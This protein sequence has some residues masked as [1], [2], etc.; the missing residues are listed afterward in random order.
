MEYKL[1]ATD[2]DGTLINSN[3][4]IP[5]SN[6]EYIKKAQEAGIVFVLASGRPTFAMLEIAKELE[7]DK[8]GGYILSYNGGEILNCK[9]GEVI[10]R[11]GLSREDVDNMYNYS[12]NNDISFLTY[13][14]NKLIT[15]E[16]NEYTRL[17]SLFTKGELNLI[18][19]LE[20]IKFEQVIKC[21]LI[22]N[23]ESVKKHSEILK[24]SEYAKNMFFAIS[25][26][27]FLEVVNINVNKGNALKRLANMLKIDISQTIAVGDSY[28]DIPLLSVTGL[29]VAPSNAKE[30]IKEMV[31]YVGVSNDEGI[32]KDLIEKYILK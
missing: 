23:E 13:N 16:D 4:K 18:D 10:Y 11:E 32:L 7:M 15:N 19:N 1:I 28:N 31:D 22:S 29:K 14:D 9:T 5:D 3:H 30:E 8:F 21:M 25:H 27:S 24:N 26:P 6:K 2:I 20:D 12:E 17:E